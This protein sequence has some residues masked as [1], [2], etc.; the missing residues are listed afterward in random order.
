MLGSRLRRGLRKRIVIIS[1]TRFPDNTSNFMRAPSLTLLLVEYRDRIT[2]A[3][4]CKAT[5]RSQ[6]ASGQVITS[7]KCWASSWNLDH[8]VQSLR[9]ST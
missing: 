1:K 7:N 5:L 9:E 3:Q 4:F 2:N 8:T 6:Q